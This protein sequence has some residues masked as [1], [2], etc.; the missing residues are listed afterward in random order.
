MIIKRKHPINFPEQ[1]EFNIISDIYHSGIKRAYKKHVGKTRRFLGNK[2]INSAKVQRSKADRDSKI[3]SNLEKLV[4]DNETLSK[5][6]RNEASKRKI[7]IVDKNQYHSIFE[8][9]INEDA[10]HDI[11]KK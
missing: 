9:G 4:R 5:K 6:L 8:L 2:L 7:G 1:K 11:S 10:I 3:V